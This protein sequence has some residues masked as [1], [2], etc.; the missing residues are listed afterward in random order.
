[1]K[2]VWMVN[3]GTEII[4]FPDMDLKK[5]LYFHPG[6]PVCL[7]YDQALKYVG[8]YTNLKPCDNPQHYFTDRRMKQLII[9][10]AG[11][12][13]LLLME[14]L[15]RKM[16]EDR[17]IH[18]ITRYPE[19]FENNPAITKTYFMES[20]GQDV[21]TE[22]FDGWE[23]LRS[24]SETC[25]SRDKKHRTDIYN[26]RL[27]VDITDHE[28]EPMIWFGNDEKAKT[29]R[30]PDM[31]YFVVQCDASHSYR[32]YERGA[33]LAKHIVDADQKNVVVIMGSNK[34]VKLEK[35]HERIIDLQ[36]KTTIREAM[37][38]VRDADY[39]IGVDSGLMHVA[40]CCHVPTVAMFSIITP[41][42]RLRYYKGTYKVISG[43]VPCIGCGDRHMTVCNYGNRN[44]DQNFRAPCMDIEPQKIYDAAMSIQPTEK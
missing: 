14:P 6:R 36:G 19:V 1:M 44:N 10:D 2:S 9:R 39:F 12:G 41:D 37:C 35:R 11:I 32:R 29:R 24:Y 20:K 33:E 21:K 28:K 22:D 4:E 31:K 30:M 42:L 26:E 23:D 13:D 25:E 27:Y 16:A 34:W 3:K 38:Q 5:Y 17:E 8:K 43:N 15:L 40:L 18:V 7:P